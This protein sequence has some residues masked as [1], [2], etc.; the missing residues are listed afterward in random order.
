[1]AAAVAGSVARGDFN[2]WSDID[3]VVVAHGLPARAPERA[4]L[5]LEDA[6]ARVQPVGYSPEEFALAVRRGDRLACEALERGVI[7]TGD[8]FFANAQEPHS[9]PTSSPP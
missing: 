3:L 1:V 8:D 6:P 7:L 5:L 9:I 4:G 2:L